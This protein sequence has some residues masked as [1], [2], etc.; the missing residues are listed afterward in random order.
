MTI[1]FVCF[2]QPSNYLSDV[3]GAMGLW[4]GMSLLTLFEFLEFVLDVAVLKYGKLRRKRKL[5]PLTLNS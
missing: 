2:F 4:L 3:G 1:I 5:T